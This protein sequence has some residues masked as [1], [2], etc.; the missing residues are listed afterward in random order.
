MKLI[1]NNLLT[2]FPEFRFLL[3]TLSQPIC[4]YFIC[5]ILNFKQFPHLQLKA[6]SDC[7]DRLAIPCSHSILDHLGLVSHVWTSVSAG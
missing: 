2:L 7:C 6:F 1:A 3:K 5:I 4:K